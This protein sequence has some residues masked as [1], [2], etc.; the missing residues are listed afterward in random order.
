[1]M[2]GFYEKKKK[3]EKRLKAVNCF[4]NPPAYLFDRI[5]NAPIY[6]GIISVFFREFLVKEIVMYNRLQNVEVFVPSNINTKVCSVVT[7]YY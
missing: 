6:D 7:H 5:I 1:M 4:E 2:K 3:K